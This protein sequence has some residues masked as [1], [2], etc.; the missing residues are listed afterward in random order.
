MGLYTKIAEQK[1]IYYEV[2]S[3]NKSISKQN[4]Y[5]KFLVLLLFIFNVFMNIKKLF[6]LSNHYE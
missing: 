4:F 2:A 1:D 6:L 3:I 5:L